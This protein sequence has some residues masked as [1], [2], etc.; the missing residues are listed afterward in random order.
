MA[1][2]YIHVPFCI[3]RCLYCDFFS[4]TDMQVKEPYISALIKEM[5]LRKEYIGEDPI[6]T[7]YFGGGTPSQLSPEDFG[8]IFEA[9]RTHF[10]IADQAEIT[11]EANPDDIRPEYLEKLRELPFNRISMG[12]QS[13]NDN[14]LNFLNRRHQAVQAIQA[15]AWCKEYGYNNLSIDLIYGLPGQTLREWEHNIH[16]VIRLDIP[17]ISAYHLTYEEDTQLYKLKDQGKIVPVEEEVSLE[18][19]SLL[20]DQLTKAGFHHYEISNF[21]KPGYISRH[22]S[23]YWTGEKY[24]GLGPSAHSY[25]QE[26]RCWNVSSLPAYIQGV[27]RGTPEIE[28]EILDPYTRYN[29][30]IIT[31]LRTYSGIQTEKLE[32]LFGKQLKEYCMQQA[33]PYINR[34]LLLHENQML[35]LSREG[36]FISDAIMSDLLWV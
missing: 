11:L 4:N 20:I 29:D 13:F 16:E 8:Q 22:N 9:I 3:K 31:G 17:H 14:D 6:E 23:S 24:I 7:V 35:R 30:Y 21:A 10:T 32:T 28:Y 33:I 25:N 26:N 15:V 18:F 36:I 1:G 2:L 34:K 27:N 5:E 19:F 12:I